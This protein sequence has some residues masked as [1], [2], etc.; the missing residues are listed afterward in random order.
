MS[1]PG[2]IM[3]QEH[4]EDVANKQMTVHAGSLPSAK[5]T[6]L[7]PALGLPDGMYQRTERVAAGPPKP[8]NGKAKDTLR[9]I[10]PPRRARLIARP[11]VCGRPKCTAPH[12]PHWEAKDTGSLFPIAG[13]RSA[14]EVAGT[15]SSQPD[16]RRVRR[17][18]ATRAMPAGRPRP[19]R[20]ASIRADAGGAGGQR[21]TRQ[22]RFRRRS[23][24]WLT[25]RTAVRMAVTQRYGKGRS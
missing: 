10:G 7:H 17:C 21:G 14:S 2:A 4:R 23:P 6:A 1:E 19:G 12:A 25:A 15:V 24:A 8:V 5:T 18:C 13:H 16:C 3:A 11:G 20:S 22:L 9:L